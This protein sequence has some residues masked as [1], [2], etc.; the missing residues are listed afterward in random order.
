MKLENK[1][2]ENIKDYYDDFWDLRLK[3]EGVDES[4][5]F[6]FLFPI[7]I[8]CRG[9]YINGTAGCLLVELEPKHTRN[10]SQLLDEIANSKW[11]VSLKNVP[12]YLISQFGRWN[13]KEEI[14]KYLS[15]SEKTK[16][17]KQYVGSVWYWASQPTHELAKDFHYWEWEK[18]IERIG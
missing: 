7:A 10:C 16:Q 2:L 17:Q 1:L 8:S 15:N 9:T 6:D 12:F 5:L 11:D 18:A 13:L 4:R 3:L 14:D